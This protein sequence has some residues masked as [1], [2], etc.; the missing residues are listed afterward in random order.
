MLSSCGISLKETGSSSWLKSIQP[1]STKSPKSPDM[2]LR[3]LCK[4]TV[5]RSEASR[6]LL[7]GVSVIP[8][9]EKTL[10]EFDRQHCLYF[11]PLPQGQRSF[12]PVFSRG[13]EHMMPAYREQRR[14]SQYSRQSLGPLVPVFPSLDKTRC[15]WPV[16]RGRIPQAGSPCHRQ[17]HIPDYDQWR[18]QFPIEQ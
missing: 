3:V 14:Q 6:C 7:H 2:R 15:R 8:A 18:A 12:L 16:R 17:R 4:S 11:L 9:P 13:R 10:I 1:S 5:R